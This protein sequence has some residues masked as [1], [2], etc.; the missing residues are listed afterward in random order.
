MLMGVLC[1][2]VYFIL[3]Y[4]RVYAY[5]QR[6]FLH[7]LFGTIGFLRTSISGQAIKG[8]RVFDG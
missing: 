4:A 8:I 6:G 5:T 2:R 3:K 1:T 7:C